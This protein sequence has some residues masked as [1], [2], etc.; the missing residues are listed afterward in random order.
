MAQSCTSRARTAATAAAMASAGLPASPPAWAASL[1]VLAIL[2]ELA[3]ADLEGPGFFCSWTVACG[4]GFG[5]AELGGTLAVS[6]L[7]S[8]RSGAG[9]TGAPPPE[10]PGFGAPGGFGAIPLD[11]G[12]PGGF[13]APGVEG[14]GCRPPGAGGALAGFMAGGVG[15]FIAGCP[16]PGGVEGGDGGGVE[17]GA[18]VAGGFGG[19][20]TMAVS[21]G[22]APWALF[23]SRRGGRTILTVSFLG[24]AILGK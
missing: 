10:A 24:S 16:P 13:G 23:P 3:E 20:L 1:G 2:I 8:G 6:F 11:G 12:T 9:A 22:F 17:G 21:R 15:G 14:G 7:V 18:P 4:I 19:K 5:P